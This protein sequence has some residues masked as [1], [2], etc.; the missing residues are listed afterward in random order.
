MTR[1]ERVREPRTVWPAAL[2]VGALS[3]TYAGWVMESVRMGRVGRLCDHAGPSTDL[4]SQ[5]ATEPLQVRGRPR[6]REVGASEGRCR[7]P[8][9][10]IPIHGEGSVVSPHVTIRRVQ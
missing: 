8:A 6:A 7:P 10:R 4:C 9:V 5:D 3:V 1:R 2:R